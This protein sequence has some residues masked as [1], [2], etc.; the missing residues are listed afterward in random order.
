M[1]KM[2]EWMQDRRLLL[3]LAAILCALQFVPVSQ[4]GMTQEEKRIARTLSQMMGAGKVEVTIY[5]NENNAAFGTSKSCVGALAVCEGAGDICVRLNISRA[6]ETLLGL[7]AE[8][9]VV[10]RMD[11]DNGR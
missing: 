11:V 3:L 7:T 5:Y 6:L 9:V 4:S 2:K 8:D 1:K 10:L